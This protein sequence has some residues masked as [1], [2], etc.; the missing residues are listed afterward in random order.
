MIATADQ[1]DFD[2]YNVGSG[3]ATSN[4]ELVQ[5]LLDNF[6]ISNDVQIYELNPDPEPIY[7]ARADI[8]RLQ[9]A[10]SWKPQYTIATAI[11]RIIRDAK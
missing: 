2:V 1:L 10:L 5:L 8:T 4:L 6:G 3:V 9:S 11:E 7:A